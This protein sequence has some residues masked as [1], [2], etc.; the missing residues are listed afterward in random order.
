MEY[1]ADALAAQEWVRL[2]KLVEDIH[3]IIPKPTILTTQDKHVELKHHFIQEKVLDGT[4][5]AMEVHR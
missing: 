3:V 2:R 4:I 1:K 5:S